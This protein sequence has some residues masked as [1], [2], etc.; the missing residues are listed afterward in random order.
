MPIPRCHESSKLQRVTIVISFIVSPAV[1]WISDLPLWQC[2]RSRDATCKAGVVV[3]GLMAKLAKLR[4]V[5]IEMREES[6][7][8]GGGRDDR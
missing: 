5:T 8:E 4:M 3:E 7:K 1:L 6:G 2:L